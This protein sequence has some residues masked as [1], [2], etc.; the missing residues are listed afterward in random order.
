ML[1]SIPVCI[2]V[3]SLFSYRELSIGKLEFLWIYFCITLFEVHWKR[4][5]QSRCWCLNLYFKL[6]FRLLFLCFYRELHW[7][8]IDNF[9]L[10]NSVFN[11]H[12]NKKI[13]QSCCTEF[14]LNRDRFIVLLHYISE[15]N[16]VLI[17]A[18]HLSDSFSY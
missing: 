15:V 6:V 9:V 5:W 18:L 12:N 13:S 17:T 14:V 10:I 7:A 16:C 8:L 2:L 4:N 11:R 3:I 1:V